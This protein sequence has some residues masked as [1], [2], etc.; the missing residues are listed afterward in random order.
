MEKI[1]FNDS[2]APRNTFDISYL[3]DKDLPFVRKDSLTLYSFNQFIQIIMKILTNFINR[4]TLLFIFFCL[5]AL[6]INAQVGLWSKF[7]TDIQNTRTYTNPFIQTTLSVEFTRPDQTK[8]TCK[9]F[10]DGGTNWKIRVM[11]DQLGQW[12]YTASFTDASQTQFTGSFNCVASDIPGLISADE[13]NPKWFGFKGGQHRLIRSFHVGDRFFASNYSD[14]NR[15][16]FLD[17]M[18]ANKYNTLSIAS[19][20]LNRNEPGR[21]RDWST[22]NLWNS[23]TNRPNPAEYAKMERILDILAAR[24]IIVFPFAG[25]FGQDSNFPTD[26]AGQTLYINYT[27]AR[28]S[29]YWNGLFNVAG[30][31]PLSEDV[32]E[33][34][35]S[36]VNA[37]G[38]KIATENTQGHLLSCH[39]ATNVNPF[40]NEAWA[41]YQI[42][43]GPKT[44]S[45]NDLYTGLMNRRNAN[46]PLYAQEVLWYGNVF[47][48]AYTDLQI[49][50]NTWVIMMAGGALNFADNNGNSS[51]GYTG[52]LDLGQRNQSKHEIVKK[53]WDFMESIPFYEMSPAQGISSS[54]YCLAKT[55]SRY[56][57]YLPSGGSVNVSTPGGTTYNGVWISG[58]NTNTRQNIP[59]TTTGNNLSAP[60][61]PGDWLLY[62]TRTGGDAQA[63]TVPTGL[64]SSNISAS[65]FT[66]SWSPSTDAVGVTGYDVFQNGTFKTSVTGTSAAI[67]GLSASTQYAMTVKAKDAA[68][69]VSAAST[70][71]NVTTLAGCGS[72]V[73]WTNNS[74][75]NQTG[76]FTA[77]FD[78]VP[79]GAGMD[80]VVG[81][82]NGST[83]AYTSLASSV[84]FYTDGFIRARNGSAYAAATPLAY[85]AGTSYR[86][87]MVVNVA[88]RKYDIYVTPAGGSQ[89]TI[90]TNYSFRTEQASVTQLNNRAVQTISCGLTVSNFTVT[91]GGG[92]SDTQA[93]SAPSGLTVTGVTTTTAGLSWTGSTD[94]VGVTGYDVYQGTTLKTSV[95]GLT[96]TVTGLTAGTGYTFTIRAKDAAGNTSPA[97][98]PAT[99]NTAATC[100]GGPQGFTNTTFTSQSGTF[101]VEFDA[102]PGSTSMDGVVSLNGSATTAYTAMVAIVRFNNTNRIDARNGGVY[103]ASNTVSY[104]P[105]TAY[106]FR[107]VLNTSTNR[108]DIYVRANGG[109]EQTIGTQ[110]AFRNN[111]ASFS[112]RCVKTEIGCIAISNFEVNGA[113]NR[114]AVNAAITPVTQPDTQPGIYPNPLGENGELTIN[115]G[116]RVE[117]AR[118]EIFDMN[119][120]LVLQRNVRNTSKT[121][122]NIAGIAR[123]GLYIVRLNS[124]FG[125]RDYKLVVQ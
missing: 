67:T 24:K 8:L 116:T 108:Y 78:V 35:L 122:L 30:P 63:P 95:T 111:T 37:L 22:P 118:I 93:P 84:Q 80:G 90:G 44:T 104:S 94:N 47:Q 87:R 69:N 62:L 3:P 114:M 112:N 102:V 86:V 73:P 121:A 16:E 72:P 11:P 38:T 40:E 103:A 56:L 89:V 124:H 110:Y 48:I 5:H 23:G 81:L 39:N 59:G 32:N 85:T 125:T 65:G 46:Q 18:V 83:T 106:H 19:H 77:E 61:I 79:S 20:L 7:Q 51:T 21:G 82:S 41:S 115:F 76:S 45:L 1:Y 113:P 43:Q 107:L 100:S 14:A 28:L 75:T 31:E 55:G 74:F 42:L 98:G 34:T 88:T 123:K 119:G 25:F 9:G 15:N 36:Q 109:A 53:V 50:Q 13:T 12:T 6:G 57:V 91:G 17:S 58:S 66:L 33:F 64:S 29:A 27:V 26:A 92:S 101:T 52:T 97:S 71:L 117:N 99:A 49:R 2:L 4:T 60:N 54:G 68:G 10:Y 70:A 120:K 96:A 105:N